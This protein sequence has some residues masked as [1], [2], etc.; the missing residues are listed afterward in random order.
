[1]PTPKPYG[2]YH[3]SFEQDSCGVGFIA[4][5]KGNASHQIVKDAT[6]ML[7]RM[8]HRAGCGCEE[9]TGDGAGIL[10]ALPDRLFRETVTFELP[11]A[12]AYGAGL[13]FLPKDTAKSEAFKKRI[14]EIV[15]EF[16]Q[17]VL[18]WRVVP[19]DRALADI[20]ISAIETEPTIEQLFVG[21]NGVSG[22]DFERVLALI[23]KSA[24][25]ELRPQDPL[26]YICTLSCRTIVYK[27]QLRTSQ[28]PLYYAD[29]RDE[30][31]ET[32]LALVHSRFSTNTFPS[33]DRAQPKR[34]VAH[35]G[36]INTLR[37]NVNRMHAREGNL[38][39]PLF[40]DKLSA[41]Y[42]LMEP[43][44]SDSGNLDNATELLA[45]SGRTLP[46]AIMM[47]I[48]EPWENH[49]QMNETKKAYYKYHSAI[50]EA[51]DGPA[52]VAFTDGKV[53]GAILDRNGLRP[54][55][56]YLTHD[57]RVIMASEVG[58]VDVA[59][60]LVRHK[61]RLLPGRM[62]LV[63]FAEGRI[64]PDRELKEKIA[65]AADYAGFLADNQ[66]V[67]ENF[68]LQKE[69]IELGEDL[70]A[71]QKAF[72]YTTEHLHF[73]LNPMA[74]DGK[75]ALG[76]MG[77]DT[78]LGA[79]SARAKMMYD[80]FQQHFAQV[81]NPPI[82]STREY[83][84]MSVQ[85]W[86]GPQ[87]NLLEANQPKAARRLLLQNP[88]LG[89]HELKA[90]L[91]NAPKDFQPKVIDITFPISEGK[92]GLKNT[93]D[94]ICKETDDAIQEGYALIVLSDR[95]TS[96]TQVP[97]SGLL[98]VSTLH[99]Y[100][101]EHKERTK[102]GLI[103]ESGEPREVH[104]FC[105]LL[106][107]GADAINPYLAYES[108]WEQHSVGNLGKMDVRNVVYN[109]KKGMEKGILK[110]MAKMGIS[111]VESYKGA[112]I[113]EAVGLNEEVIK[114]S[115]EGTVSRLSGIGYDELA[116]ETLMRH[117]DG[118]PEIGAPNQLDNHGE[119]HFR[120]NGESHNWSPEAIHQ[121]QKAAWNNS[122]DAYAEF[123]RII[124]EEN[125]RN[126]SIRGMLDFKFDRPS[127]SIDEVEATQ[128]IVKR[129]VTGA[130]SLGSISQEAHQTLAIA[131]NQLG[132]KS[133]TGEGGEDYVRFADNR[134]SAIKQVASGRF[135]VTNWYLHNADELQ[136]KMAQGAK[137]GEGGE[138][139][140]HKVSEYI[141]SVR[142]STPGVGLISPPPHHD[143]Y[144]IED[145]AQLIHD[146][147]NAN[148]EA[149]ISVKLVSKAGVGTIAAGVAK[150]KA[151]HIL[152][153]GH[154]GGTGASP[155]NSIK[156]A[157][158]PW[159]LGLAETHQTLVM[160]DLR[161]RVIVQTDG[162]LKTGRDVVIAALLG[163]EE[164][165]FA[166]APLITMGCI[167]MRKCHLN[168][169]PVGI[170]TQDETL[171][172]KFKGTPESVINYL[173]LVAEEAREWMAKLGFRSINEMIGHVE[174]LKQRSE[175]NHW[176]AEHLDF[177]ALLT[178][179]QHPTRNNV[180]TFNTEK[181][182]HGLEF[183]LDNE[184]IRLAQPT[185]QSGE[186]VKIE[187][188]VISTNRVV[189]TMLSFEISKQ[190]GEPALPEDTIH[191]KLN[192]SAGQSLGAFAVAGL[193]LEVEG[194]AN[195]YV[196]KGLSGGKIVVYPPKQSSFPTDDNVIIGN[197]AL[198]GATGGEAYFSGIAAERFAVRN[199]GAKAVVE[200]VGDHGCEYMTGG[201]V[202]ILGRIGRNFAAGMSGGIAYLYSPQQ[203]LEV[204]VNLETVQIESLEQE[205]VYEVYDLVKKHY[206]TTGS[207]VAK[208]IVEN[209]NSEKDSFVRIMP[210]D[211]KAVL[212]KQK[213]QQKESNKQKTAQLQHQA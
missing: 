163:A 32:Y 155:L 154:S 135:G 75:E 134:R 9:N 43:D 85:S 34:Y 7:I 177:S 86:V 71:R 170:A 183:A 63:D 131:M 72:G 142:R 20:G 67:L 213:A 101:I 8:E 97:V 112:Q 73:L 5:V 201:R 171:R 121:L 166:T 187:L 106:G 48:P 146:L 98:A 211:Y 17:I 70:I 69:Q 152:I 167:M 103:L 33:W 147:K 22:D 159:E 92:A 57:E 23:R 95:N 14:E 99:H 26:F 139:P 144:S 133:N 81:T 93:L 116:T 15:L 41:F 4:N 125:H 197:V 46:E 118:Y 30:R 145:L 127:I 50:Q 180:G 151:D 174:V 51:W 76:S 119:Y 111:T 188:P 109:Y 10:T 44:T 60:E 191:V 27:G 55:R 210:I 209:W 40:G 195:D 157:G 42:P 79:F 35:N 105:V 150:A 84:V 205:D 59:P 83:L 165:G 140:G 207:L 54:A 52:C 89:N 120:A 168:T 19:T 31:Y 196:G 141:G 162:Q 3:P 47:L 28:V 1:M 6:E 161:S 87:W 16:G 181:Q 178:P 202:A 189:G 107:Y 190:F 149:R 164:F 182:D 29:L 53:I 124:N 114:G 102:V 45:L 78:P 156:H 184:L 110:V 108:L 90:I 49:E 186:K 212:E 176:K 130:M 100:L 96:R 104:H 203:N 117:A 153:S 198:Y 143:I 206:D 82:D 115:F 56:V 148:R 62:F 173:W 77:N 2:L 65:G 126:N 39:S 18:G 37:G 132:G 94:R 128:E 11:E 175:G 38:A 64:V 137:P 208:K 136:I 36:E 193:T 61:A 199:S 158:L 58:V 138:L 24:S 113:F 122:R 169:C 12:G 80:Y 74:R 192:G 204:N 129:F 123:S 88:L 194:D 68:D 179:A 13:F 91:E 25:R 200:G 160:N 172:K 66:L 185:L 21:A